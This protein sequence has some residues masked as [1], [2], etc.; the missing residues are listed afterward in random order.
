MTIFYLWVRIV[1]CVGTHGAEEE[2]RVSPIAVLSQWR[3]RCQ[4]LQY[5]L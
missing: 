1:A 4:R 5:E 3:V 2:S